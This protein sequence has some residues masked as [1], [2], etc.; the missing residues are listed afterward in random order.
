MRG[1]KI[2]VIVMGVMIVVGFTALIVIIVGR[3]SNPRP[4]ASNAPA[5]A[6]TSTPAPVI[7][8]ASVA[9]P[10]DIPAGARIEGMSAAPDRVVIAL[11]LPD[12]TRQLIV[13]ELAT[14]RRLLTI[15]LQAA[16]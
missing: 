6:T 13:I 11:A 4:A 16:Q 14:G 5:T 10:V 8:P 1:L 9:P 12:G 15:P 7:G 2:V 3:V